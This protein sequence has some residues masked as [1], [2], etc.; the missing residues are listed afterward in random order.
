MKYA[1]R[2]IESCSD[3]GRDEKDG[4]TQMILRRR[5]VCRAKS[6]YIGYLWVT[7]DNESKVFIMKSWD[8]FNLATSFEDG[9]HC[10]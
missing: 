8:T 5:M 2:I 1:R 10:V 6:K 7:R 4:V 3:N 9:H